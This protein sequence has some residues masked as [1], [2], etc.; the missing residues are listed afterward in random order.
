MLE[1]AREGLGG[2][3]LKWA[4]VGAGGAGAGAGVGVDGGEVE[5]GLEL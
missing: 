1:K 2:V 5:K 4:G 3:L